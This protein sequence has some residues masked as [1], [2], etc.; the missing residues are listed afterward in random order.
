MEYLLGVRRQRPNAT[1]GHMHGDWFY[2]AI[3]TPSELVFVAPLLAHHFIEAQV[4]DKPWISEV[5]MIDDGDD[6]PALARQLLAKYDLA[7]QT[8]GVPREALASTVFEIQSVAPGT[9]FH[10]TWDIVAPM[11]A[12]KDDEEIELM[13]RAARLT[14]AIFDDVRQNLVYGMT[15]ADV[16]IEVEHQM[17][18][19][20]AEGS[21]FVTGIM[22]KGPGV[23]DTLEG[24]SRAGAVELQPGRVIAFDFGVVL[25]G[26][27]SDFG[28]TI[29]CGDPD[30]ELRRIHELVMTSQADGMKAMKAG[31]ITAEEANQAARNIIEAAG[32]G[33]N[34]FHRLGH[35]I[36][37]DVHE[38]PFLAKG[39]TTTLEANMCFTVEPSIWVSGK[40]FTRVEDV[41]VVGPDG[42]SSLNEY[43]REILVL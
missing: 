15:E 21:S 34:F 30:A 37:I 10:S 16:M 1:K 22:V 23:D 35:G 28:R 41:V 3:I 5:V 40:C 24:V 43:T 17:L 6:V 32:Y 42:G 2:G 12:I 27:V 11:R 29:H 38:P 19:H 9:T 7:G 39:D 31:Q 33:P 4:T 8:L 36:G 13:R 14:D 20:G 18:K 26:Y 25:D